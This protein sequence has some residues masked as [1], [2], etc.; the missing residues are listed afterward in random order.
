MSCINSV[1]LKLEFQLLK[2]DGKKYKYEIFRSAE[3]ICKLYENTGRSTGIL[4]ILPA[5]L[6]NS[7]A[8]NRKCPMSV[9]GFKIFAIFFKGKEFF[10]DEASLKHYPLDLSFFPSVAPSGKYQLTAKIFK[11]DTKELVVNSITRF[12][13]KYNNNKT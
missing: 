10:Q 13:I 8:A 1:T 11:S 5:I 9:S 12:E 4:R 3:D 6:N 7:V 2:W